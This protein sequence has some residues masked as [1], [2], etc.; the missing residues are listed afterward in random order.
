MNICVIGTGYVGL[1]TGAVFA[2]LGHKVYCVDIDESKIEKL[3][4]GEIPFFEPGLQELVKKNLS[5]GRLFFTTS[6]EESVPNSKVVFICVGTP[7][8]ENGEPDL[9]YLY[10]ATESTAKYLKDYTLIA[11]KSTVP[12]GVEKELETL[13]NKASKAEFEFASCPEFLREGSAVEDTKM[14]DRIVIGTNSKKAADILLKLYE[15]FNGQRIICD[16]T[17]AQMTKY[18]ANSLLATKISFANAIANLC[19]KTGADVE[20]VLKGVGLDK[21]LGRQFLYPGV[22]YGGSCFPKDVAAFIKIAEKADVDFKLFKAVEEINNNQP[23]KLFEKILKELGDLENDSVAV[24]GL[25]FKPN[26][27]D[28]REAPSIKIINMLLEK[29][30]KIKVY[31]PEAMENVRRIYGE[32]LQYEEDPYKAVTG[33]SA[34]LLITEWNEFRELDLTEVKRLMKKAAI[35]DG[36]NI[37]DP[38]EVKDLGFIYHGIGRS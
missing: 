38:Q 27:D 10:Q 2:D 28:I 23:K 21:R 19:E 14:P 1:V 31:D 22:G 20:M 4:Q 16:L 9:K 30:A 36:R 3:L 35:F 29:G 25:A 33:T 24:L 18:A 7:P 11:I 37:Y 26:T 5:Q 17:S 12:I 13:I 15:N 32:K 8:K 6:Y 34:M